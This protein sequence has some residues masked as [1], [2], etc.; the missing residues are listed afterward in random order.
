MGVKKQYLKKQGEIKT[1]KFYATSL[2]FHKKA[3]ISNF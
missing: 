1:L 2:E 3:L